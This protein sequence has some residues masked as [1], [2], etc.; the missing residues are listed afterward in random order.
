[1][2][3]KTYGSNATRCRC[4]TAPG[5]SFVAVPEGLGVNLVLEFVPSLNEK[6][7]KLCLAL[8]AAVSG[9]NTSLKLHRRIFALRGQKS[10]RA[11]IEVQ[12]G[13]YILIRTQTNLGTPWRQSFERFSGEY[14]EQRIVSRYS[15]LLMIPPG[16]CYNSLTFSA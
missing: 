4:F 2:K 6:R 3:S 1:M 9:D 8:Q 11:W 15:A 13:L 12:A 10:V 14:E 16:R 7:A 5:G